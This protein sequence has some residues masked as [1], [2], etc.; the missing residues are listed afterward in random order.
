MRERDK[1]GSRGAISCLFLRRGQIK[2]GGEGEIERKRERERE[3]EREIERER[4]REREI[5]GDHEVRYLVCSC[6]EDKLNLA[7]RER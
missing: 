7:E 3:R 1:R 5:R 4:E 2:S 6:G